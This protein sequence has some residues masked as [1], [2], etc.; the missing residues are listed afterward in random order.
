MD[1]WTN[2]AGEYNSSTGTTV[3]EFVHHESDRRVMLAD[4]TIAG[5]TDVML[6]NEIP[7][8][9][10]T[11]QD[12][13]FSDEVWPYITVDE[14]FSNRPDGVEFQI[15][16]VDKDVT[17]NTATIQVYGTPTVPCIEPIK[18]EIPGK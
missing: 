7:D 2:Y 1:H 16:A 13:F 11:L 10:L 8:F 14:W 17:P 9:E 3:L 18:V 12:D 15:R 4:I 5:Q 6:S